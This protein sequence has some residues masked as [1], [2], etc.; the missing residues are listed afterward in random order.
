MIEAAH[1]IKLLRHNISKCHL[2]HQ[3]RYYTRLCHQWLVNFTFILTSC[4][5]HFF[6]F[7]CHEQHPLIVPV[8]S[9]QL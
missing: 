4:S 7:L 8:L 3:I 9:N 6:Q 2:A 5:Q 1:Q